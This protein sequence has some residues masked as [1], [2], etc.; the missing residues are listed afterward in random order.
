MTTAH[1]S[2]LG[3]A[4]APGGEYDPGLLFPMARAPLRDALGIGAPLPFYGVDI[5]NAYEFSWLDAR[6]KPEIAIA[7]FRVP[8]DSPNLVESKSF[9]LY[10][11]SWAQR[12]LADGASPADLL[13]A[14]VSAAAGAEVG[15]RLVRPA[16]FDGVRLEPLAGQCI[17]SLDVEIET[18]GPP[19]SR[20]LRCA[21]AADV[22]RETL[23]SHLLKSNCP[24]TGQPDWASVQIRYVGPRI[25]R[26]GLLRYL[27]S[28]RGHSD[29]H[30]ACVERMFRDIQHQ[31][32]PLHLE[33]HARYTRRGGLDINPWR[34]TDARA[35]DNP[36]GVRQ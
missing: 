10:L 6:G 26:E 1:D 36:R 28:F 9:K 4:T 17:D 35:P 2:P 11:N 5:W 24:V 25:D 13:G 19:Q 14:D 21:P 31:C 34:S 22:A 23:I 18:Y 30:E 3:K 15:V 33:V 27:V 32:A 29:F 8:A 16:Q 20:Y 7:E 12:R